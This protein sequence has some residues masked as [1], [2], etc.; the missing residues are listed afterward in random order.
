MR[1]RKFEL[2]SRGSWWVGT[3]EISEPKLLSP[4]QLFGLKQQ[5]PSCWLI[6]QRY[7][8]DS[9]LREAQL[10]NKND[11]LLYVGFGERIKKSFWLEANKIIQNP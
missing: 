9:S 5:L 7:G 1:E 3:N 2:A 4:R 11:R 8:I 6:Y 10:L